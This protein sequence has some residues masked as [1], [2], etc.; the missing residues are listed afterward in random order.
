MRKDALRF[1]AVLF[2]YSS[3]MTLAVTIGDH[4]IIG[5]DTIMEAQQIGNFVSIGK[6]CVIVCSLTASSFGSPTPVTWWRLDLLLFLVQ[7]KRSVIKDCV[8]ILDNTVIA[9]GTVI[10]SFS[11]YGGNPGTQTGC[12]TYQ[13]PRHDLDSRVAL[14]SSCCMCLRAVMMILS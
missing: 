8:E 14:I 11:I 1:T 7:G 6:N 4:C 10:A 3:V 2:W 9:P 5:S 12:R 13:R